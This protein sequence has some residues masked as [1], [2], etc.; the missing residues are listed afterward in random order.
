M[1]YAE[2]TFG[3]FGN[4]VV[5]RFVPSGPDLSLEGKRRCAQDYLEYHAAY[6]LSKWATRLKG[7]VEPIED[8]GLLMLDETESID[9]GFRF[10]RLYCAKASPERQLQRGCKCEW[11]S[12]ISASTVSPHSHIWSALHQ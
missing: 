8:S 5:I 2:V 4:P 3:W 12:N 9:L 1:D 11:H 10:A 6:G 7:S